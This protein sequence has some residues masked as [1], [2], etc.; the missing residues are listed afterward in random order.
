MGTP[1]KV[2]RLDVA[3]DEGPLVEKL[4]GEAERFPHLRG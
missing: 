4:D 1:D 2:A 3:V